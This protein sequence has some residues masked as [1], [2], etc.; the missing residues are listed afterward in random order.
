MVLCLKAYK[1]RWSTP[2]S[3]QHSHLENIR[4]L[5]INC[6]RISFQT[7]FNK[8]SMVNLK[9]VWSGIM[10]S[11][12]WQWCLSKHF[13]YLSKFSLVSEIKWKS[14]Y[15][16]TSSTLLKVLVMFESSLSAHLLPCLRDNQFPNLVR[17]SFLQVLNVFFSITIHSLV[18]GL[19]QWFYF[20]K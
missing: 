20:V 9:L 16:L 18:Q 8:T 17:F 10:V 4:Y 14:K 13:A 11:V 6:S 3:C 12:W 5:F 1:F 19:H 2:S 7:I 15:Y